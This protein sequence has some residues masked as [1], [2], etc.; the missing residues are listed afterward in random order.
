MKFYLVIEFSSNGLQNEDLIVWMR[1]A[2][3]P[4][5]RKLYRRVAFSKLPTLNGKLPGRDAGSN[6]YYRL[7]IDYREFIKRLFYGLRS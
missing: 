5:F 1:T 2:A 6:G 3:L 4:N 7:D